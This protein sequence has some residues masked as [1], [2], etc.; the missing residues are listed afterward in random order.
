MF[1]DDQ[2]LFQLNA[3]G[4]IECYDDLDCPDPVEIPGDSTL[5]QFSCSGYL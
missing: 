2:P 3:D 4:Y 5:V 1:L